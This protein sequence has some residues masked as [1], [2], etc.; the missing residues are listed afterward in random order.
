LL[1]SFCWVL[2]YFASGLVLGCKESRII[3]D[4]LKDTPEGILGEG[5]SGEDKMSKRK[6]KKEINLRVTARR[7]AKKDG[8]TK[9]DFHAILD[10]ASQPIEP[11]KPE[12]E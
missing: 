9:K 5:V 10:K 12:P 11:D 4:A 2:A 3:K 7:R 6:G 1:S 8:V